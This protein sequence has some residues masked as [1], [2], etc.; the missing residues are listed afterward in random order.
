[1]LMVTFLIYLD[2]I[3]EK[4][5]IRILSL[6]FGSRSLKVIL[7]DLFRWVTGHIFFDNMSYLTQACATS[8]HNSLL[9]SLILAQSE[10]WRHG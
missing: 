3:L 2:E 10:R 9:E 5:F 4:R 6:I 1:M 8:L 7:C